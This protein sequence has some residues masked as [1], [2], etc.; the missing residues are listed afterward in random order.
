MSPRLHPPKL[1]TSSARAEPGGKIA[2]R[3][4]RKTSP[5]IMQQMPPYFVFVKARI[6]S[7]SKW[8]LAGAKLLQ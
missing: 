8:V 4:K 1:T 7:P 5:M 3:G 2:K 6:M